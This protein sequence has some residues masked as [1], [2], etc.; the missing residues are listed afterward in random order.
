MSSRHGKK[1]KVIWIDLDKYKQIND[2]H[3]HRVG[4]EVLCEVARR[5]Q[6]CLP[7]SDSVARVGGD[8]FSVLAQDLT[9]Q[10]DAERVAATI[11]SAFTLPFELPSHQAMLTASLGISMFP[12]HGEDP[13]TLLRNG[14]MALYSAKRAGGGTFRMFRSS[15]NDSLQRQLLLE[16]ELK[17]AIDR[18]ELTLESQPLLDRN[19]HLDGVEELLRWNSPEAGHVSPSEFIPIAEAAGLIPSIGEWVTRTACRN[20]AHWLQLGYDVPCTAVNV[21]ALQFVDGEF[22]ALMERILRECGLP[23]SRLELE[24][25]ETKLMNNLPQVIE[26]IGLLRLLGVRFAI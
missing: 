2:M 8:E 19:S 9:G 18:N 7:K 3:G 22:P 26:Q 23:P 12:E 25:T 4:D 1:A 5:L 21:S 24:I 11:L 10:D 6:G 20:A 14:D 13:I 17:T 15:L 16:R